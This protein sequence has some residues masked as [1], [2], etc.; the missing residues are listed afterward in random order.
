MLEYERNYKPYVDP[1]QYED[2]SEAVRDF[3]R[4]IDAALITIESVIGGG[5][6]YRK[7][8]FFAIQNQI[9]VYGMRTHSS[10]SAI[11]TEALNYYFIH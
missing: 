5:T 8:S 6:F 10:R 1:H 2:P 3:T 9:Q 7:I 4:E 11:K